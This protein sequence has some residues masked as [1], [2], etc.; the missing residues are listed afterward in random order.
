MSDTQWFYVATE[1]ERQGPVAESFLKEAVTD[2][3]LTADTLVWRDGMEAWTRLGDVQ[4][5]GPP[6]AIAPESVRAAAAPRDVP[7][8]RQPQHLRASPA[9]EATEASDLQQAIN[10]PTGR[11]VL[12]TIATVGI[13]AYYWI[14]RNTPIIG[15]AARREVASESYLLTMIGLSAWGSYIFNL[16][17]GGQNA[18][19]AV[20]GLAMLAGFVMLVMWAFRAKDA[21]KAYA[22]SVHGFD[23]PMNG[24]YTFFL[25][26]FYINYCIN[27]IAVEKGRIQAYAR[28]A[29]A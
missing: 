8:P 5:G 10:M 27:D 16:Q 6:A 15:N 24:F 21:L 7:P 23:Y 29:T 22:S 1:G 26:Y 20:G 13:Y 28:R 19:G 18:A 11:F 4:L 17:Q 9:P 2:G 3:R 25:S 14:L 12:F